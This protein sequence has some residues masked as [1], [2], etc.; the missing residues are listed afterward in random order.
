[1]G[2]ENIPPFEISVKSSETA[3]REALAKLITAMRP[4][5]L[6]VEECGTV[7][8]V[9]AEVLNN[10]VEH[11]YPANEAVGEITIRCAY[12]KTGLRISIVDRGRAMPDGRLPIGQQACLDVDLGDLPEGGFGWLLIQDLAQDL[13]YERSNGENHLHM[14]LAV[15]IPEVPS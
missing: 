10:I 3:V 5:K 12:G 14:R 1:M 9:L 6:S 2:V 4:L 7:E 15:G 8:L 13:R 11:A